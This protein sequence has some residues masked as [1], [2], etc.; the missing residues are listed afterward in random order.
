[1][2][3]H[4]LALLEGPIPSA[5][6]AEPVTLHRR[7]LL[8]VPLLA[9]AGCG[10]ELK[11]AAALQFQSIALTGF[12]PRSPLA[13]ELRTALERSVTVM[14]SPAQA[15]VVFQA[16]SDVRTNACAARTDPGLRDHPVPRD[17]LHRIEDAGQG[18]G[19]TAAIPRNAVRRRAAGCVA[20]VRDPLDVNPSRSAFGA[21]AQGA[22]TSG[23]ARPVSRWPLDAAS[24]VM[25]RRWR[26]SR[27][28]N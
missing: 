20:P 22:T 11:R 21:P 8:A 15:Q 18:A 3:A 10:F 2:P 23:L 19:R 28:R 9:L 16:L 25:R 26:A 12:A 5:V 1:M 14:E 6:R 27:R 24:H 13:E 4:G 7:R 17:D